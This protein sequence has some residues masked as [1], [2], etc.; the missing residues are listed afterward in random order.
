[1]HRFRWDLRYPPP[2]G[3]AR[4]LPI[5]AIYRRTPAVPEGPLAHPGEYTV[6]L[7]VDGE[8]RTTRFRLEIDPRVTTPGAGL[9][10]QFR[11]SH[12]A[13]AGLKKSYGARLRLVEQSQR[14]MAQ[15]ESPEQRRQL[16]S[17]TALIRQ[18]DDLRRD[19]L[20]LLNSL[21]ESD[22]APTAPATEAA[23]QLRERLRQLPE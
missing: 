18:I 20:T 22:T 16:E 21:Q 17:T 13:W 23:R 10:E 12:E 8:S 9:R 3:F 5:S 4:S 2:E 19:L 1:M 7:T 15:P 11:L 14:L 6:T